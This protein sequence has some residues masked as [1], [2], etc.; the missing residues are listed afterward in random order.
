MY[1]RWEP[2]WTSLF[3]VLFSLSET[4]NRS[5][6]GTYVVFWKTE[7]ITNWGLNP[8]S[9]GHIPDAPP[10]ELSGITGFP[11]LQQVQ[12]VHQIAVYLWTSLL[13]SSCRSFILKDNVEPTKD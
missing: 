9:T 8:G 13:Q 2:I 5:E 10:T 6:S 12:T 11:H 4:Y 7:R 3:F 1:C